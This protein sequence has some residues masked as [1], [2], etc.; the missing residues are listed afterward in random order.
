MKLDRRHMA[1]SGVML[2][3]SII[4]NIWVFT[5]S[6]TGAV[7][8][9]ARPP[10]DA[11]AAAPALPG[12]SAPFD[13]SQVEPLPDIGLDRLPEWPRNPFENVNE[14]PEVIAAIEA[15]PEAVPDPDPVVATILY[16]SDRKAAVV[17]GRIV[18]IGD[19]VGTA[20]VVDILPKAVIIDSPERGQRTL[21]M[22]PGSGT[23]SGGQKAAPA[24]TV[25]PAEA[26]PV[27]RR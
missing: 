26:A 6:G 10:V 5:G 13:P 27:N 22:K 1:V 19:M 8:T 24:A 21:E 20:K 18:R 11:V 15:T 2:V 7:V 16:S 17:N 12:G 23:G 14:A 3:G 25:P 4:Y 9:Q